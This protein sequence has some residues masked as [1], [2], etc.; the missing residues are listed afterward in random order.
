MAGK[1]RQKNWLINPSIKYF[2]LEAIS[3]YTP[4]RQYGEKHGRKYRL[5]EPGVKSAGGNKD[6]SS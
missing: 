6:A 3:C 1:A 5:S 4:L 2:P